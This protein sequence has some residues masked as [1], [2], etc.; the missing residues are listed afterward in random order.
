MRIIY[1]TGFSGAGKSSVGEALAARLNRPLRDLDDAI[2]A[3]VGRPIPAIFTEDGESAFRQYET[4]ALRALAA[5]ESATAP[6]VATGGG[7]VLAADNRDL[8]FATGW[9][10]CLEAR[11][12]TIYQR[13]SA[14]R[15]A[16]T[17]RAVRPLLDD[18]VQLGRIR[19]L[20]DARQPVYAHAHWTVHTD[21]LSPDQIAE[22]IAHA[23]ALLERPD[24]CADERSGFPV[25][26][27]WFG[28]DRPLT[29]LPIV[30]TTPA[31]AL[32]LAREAAALAPDALELRADY[33]T[34]LTPP[35]LQTLLTD[36][37]AIGLPLIFTNRT[38]A[39][40]GARPQDE[41]TRVQLI[42]T[43]IT[44]RV[45][46]VVDIEL[47]TPPEPRATLL[48]AAREHGVPVLMSFHDFTAT[49]PDAVLLGHLEAM[50]V[51]GAA[52]GK[53]AIMPRDD[54]DAIRLLT[55]CHAVSTGALGNVPIPIAVMGMGA[56]GVLT[57]VL[58]HRAGSALT[59]AAAGAG[60]GS[61]PGQLTLA[62]L[63]ACWAVTA[64][65]V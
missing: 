10:I 4:A 50:A 6:I 32:A 33:L 38:A 15:Q 16:G 65:V 22:E 40:G 30:A 41:A 63:R 2:V 56:Q 14:H 35:I 51:A 64:S 8:M 7:A 49:P 57:R 34:D 18:A 31:L 62:Q 54:A 17:A 55:F 48:A 44:S 36:L 11:P 28:R 47:G 21:T 9:V 53:L 61:A 13:V 37:A 26:A 24:S 23:I 19:A 3:R 46:A 59:F 42:A 27:K 12:E 39:E 52:A 5:E 45:P 60:Q 58:G 1:L 43:A 29:C 20:K 25:G